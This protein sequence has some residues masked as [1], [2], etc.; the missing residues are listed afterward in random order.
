[1]E[2]HFSIC[3]KKI[4]ANCKPD[5]TLRAEKACELMAAVFFMRSVKS[6]VIWQE[7][8]QGGRQGGFK[9]S[10]DDNCKNC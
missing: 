7:K 2:R 6:H 3:H 8:S 4:H 1:M 9:R 5:S 10:N